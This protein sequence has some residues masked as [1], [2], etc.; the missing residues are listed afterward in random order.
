MIW[1]TAKSSAFY[2]TTLPHTMTFLTVFL[3]TFYIYNGDRAYQFTYPVIF[4][5]TEFRHQI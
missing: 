4:S 5:A 2:S 1:A 3:F